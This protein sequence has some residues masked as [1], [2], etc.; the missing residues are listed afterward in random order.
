MR[1]TKAALHKEV[2]DPADHGISSG[3]LDYADCEP[4]M[5]QVCFWLILEAFLQ[6]KLKLELVI[7]GVSGTYTMPR[8]NLALCGLLSPTVDETSSLLNITSV[9]TT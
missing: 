5:D 1:Q 9:V 3:L 2:H 7:V 4:A 8:Q 6:P